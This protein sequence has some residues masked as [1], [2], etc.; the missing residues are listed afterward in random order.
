MTALRRLYAG[1]LRAYGEFRRDGGVV[2]SAAL[3]YY[4][5]FAMAPGLV[6]LVVLLVTVRGQSGVAKGAFVGLAEVLGPDLTAALLT[7]VGTAAQA[8]AGAVV[9][10]VGF[11]VLMWAGILLFIQ[12]QDVLNRMWCVRVVEGGKGRGLMRAR[13]GQALVLLVPVGLMAVQS[14]A[15][16][17][18]ATA[19]VLP[20]LGWLGGAVQFLGS[21]FA[22]M[23]GAWFALFMVF[24]FLPDVF[25]PR[26]PALVAGAVAAVGWTLGTYLFGLYLSSQDV[27]AGYGAAGALF[28]LILWLNY[29]ARLVLLCCRAMKL[30]AE[31]HD[32]VRPRPYAAL[33][34]VS[35]E[36]VDGG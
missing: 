15:S 30:W 28:V 19:S 22:L 5:L 20:A 34:R 26:A 16:A 10:A 14:V 25:V 2:L 23:L 27:V 18:I 21:P 11:V 7:V 36:G 33:V 31:K 35:V 32:G 12:L 9:G 29:S 8:Q 1:T 24:L 13:L 4:L 6:F 17:L 3:A